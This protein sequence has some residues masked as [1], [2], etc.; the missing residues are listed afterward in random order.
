M[1]KMLVFRIKGGRG[2]SVNV[3]APTKPMSAIAATFEAMFY[4]AVAS[5]QP[6]LESRGQGLLCK[7]L[8][9]II[10]TKLDRTVCRKAAVGV[11]CL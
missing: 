9:S 5:P 7:N 8:A 11:G 3:W 6:D 10:T 4:D 2:R 1:Q